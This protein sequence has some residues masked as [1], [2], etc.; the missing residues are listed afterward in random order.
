MSPPSDHKHLP[1]ACLFA[2]L[3][4]LGAAGAIAAP[5]ASADSLYPAGASRPLIVPSP[6]VFAR[7]ATV[8][9]PKRTRKKARKPALHGD[10]AR[11]LL[12]FQAMLKYYY[13]QG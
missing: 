12:A 2:V 10:P 11:A 4:A 9:H 6:G 3:L 13:L 5:A 1:K 8:A 7:Q